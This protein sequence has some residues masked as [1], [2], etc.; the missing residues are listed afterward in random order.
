MKTQVI[1]LLSLLLTCFSSQFTVQAQD[2]I[3]SPDNY[4]V[5]GFVSDSLT[6]ETLIG[7]NIYL[8]DTKYGTVSDSKG[9]FTLE[10]PGGN[11]TL[12]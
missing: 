10:A 11:Y 1:C 5:M 4:T 3:H 2:N 12:I 8:E 7:V 9:N 6:G